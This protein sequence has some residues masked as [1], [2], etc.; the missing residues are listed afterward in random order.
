MLKVNAGKRV[1]NIIRIYHECEV[2]IEKSI[3]RIAVWHH[4]ACQL[5]QLGI[6]RPAEC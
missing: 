6:T 2:G 3:R 4:M 1:E 5:I